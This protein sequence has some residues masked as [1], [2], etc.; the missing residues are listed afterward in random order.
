MEAAISKLA[1]AAGQLL[2]SKASQEEGESC[3]VT[4]AHVYVYPNIAVPQLFLTF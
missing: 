4:L 1:E 3:F 2:D